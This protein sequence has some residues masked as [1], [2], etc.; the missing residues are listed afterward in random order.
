MRNTDKTV[1]HNRPDI[2]LFEKSNRIFHLIDSSLPNSRNLQTA[3]TEKNE[4][5]CR[6]MHL[7]EISVV[8]KSGICLT[9]H[10]FCNR[11]HSSH[12]ALYPRATRLNRFAVRDRTKICNLKYTQHSLVVK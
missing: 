4:K 1:P 8:N 3:Y 10:Y 2:T 11:S 12:T 7:T 6:V 9:C 5:M